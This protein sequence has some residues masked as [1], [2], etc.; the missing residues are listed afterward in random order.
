[1]AH[2]A[3]SQPGPWRPAVAARLARTLGVTNGMLQS[4]TGFAVDL[5]WV[6]VG[7]AFFAPLVYLRRRYQRRDYARMAKS[8]ARATAVVVEAWKSEEGWSITYEFQ[9]VGRKET[10]RRTETFETLKSAPAS[11][12]EK[13]QVAYEPHRP[14][15]SVPLLHPE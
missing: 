14:F 8:G 11:V 4:F 1:V 10:V 15:Y 13:I 6:L 9:P 3:F 5:V 2:G 12:G 7:V